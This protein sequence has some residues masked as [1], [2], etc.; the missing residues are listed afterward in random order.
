MIGPYFFDEHLTG[1][2]YLNFLREELPILL[3]NVNL[4]LRTSFFLQHDGAPPHYHA[5]VRRYLDNWKGNNWIGRGGPIE[6]PAR[7]PDL[8]PLDFFLWGHVE[9]EV[10]KNIPTTRDDM[11]VRI[12]QSFSNISEET[13]QKVQWSFKRRLEMCVSERGGLFEHLL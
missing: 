5:D 9:Q 1:Q 7:S 2:V 3:E 6:W 13:L 11:K 12:T 8:T 4:S 10:Y